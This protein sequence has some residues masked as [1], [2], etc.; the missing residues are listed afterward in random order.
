MFSYIPTAYM[1]LHVHVSIHRNV[2][3]SRSVPPLPYTHTHAPTHSLLLY[4][5]VAVETCLFAW[6]LVSND[7]R[8]AA[9]FAVTA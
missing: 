8:I 6:P 7:C 4:S 1:Y 5:L 9:Y 2:Y 3:I